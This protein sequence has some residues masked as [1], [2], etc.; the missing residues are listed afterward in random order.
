MVVPRV[1]SWGHNLLSSVLALMLIWWNTKTSVVMGLVHYKIVCMLRLLNRKFDL[2]LECTDVSW[3]CHTCWLIDCILL[4]QS[5]PL[6]PISDFLGF[7]N[8]LVFKVFDIILTR[9]IFIWVWSFISWDNLLVVIGC[10]WLWVT[11]WSFNVVWSLY[12]LRRV[13]Y[14]IV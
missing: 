7:L 2:L 1:E 11:S 13:P 9:L 10:W 4:Q 5:F 6:L 12:L 8:L 14:L 3:N